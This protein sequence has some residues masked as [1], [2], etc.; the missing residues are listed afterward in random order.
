VSLTGVSSYNPAILEAMTRT[1]PPIP[2][3]DDLLALYSATEENALALITDAETLVEAGRFPRAYALATLALEELGKGHLCLLAVV[4]PEIPP[5]E[6]WDDFR[7][8]KGKLARAYDYDAF[9]R[10]EPYGTMTQHESKK[11]KFSSLGQS[12]KLNGLYVDYKRGKILRPS[13]ITERIAREH[14]RDVGDS[15]IFSYIRFS[16]G[17]SVIDTLMASKAQREILDTQ[18]AAFGERLAEALRQAVLGG[19]KEH[20]RELL[21]QAGLTDVDQGRVTS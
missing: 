18:D 9:R 19:S 11:K 10:P 20:L 4:W 21:H 15:L 8:H 1:C 14:V 6:F 3:R 17:E 2:P 16:P 13:R 12:R 7:D 5:E